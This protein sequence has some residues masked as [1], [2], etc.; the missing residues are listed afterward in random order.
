MRAPPRAPTGAHAQPRSHPRPRS[1]AARFGRVCGCLLLTAA[2]LAGCGGSRTDAGDHG[3]TPEP[4]SPA[5]VC[6]AL[7][8]YWAQEAL[9]D[10]RWAGLDWEQKGLSN[11]QLVLHDQIVAAARA[12]R[13]RHGLEAAKELVKRQAKRRCAAERGATGSSENWRSRP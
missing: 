9:T 11:Q 2:A 8:S 3:P 12:E 6:A 4:S 13:R 7:I 1:P 10:G 5:E